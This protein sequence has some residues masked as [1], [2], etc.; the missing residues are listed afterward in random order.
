[1]AAARAR[2]RLLDLDG[3][4]DLDENFREVRLIVAGPGVASAPTATRSR[5]RAKLNSMLQKVGETGQITSHWES[6]KC[7][8]TGRSRLCV[9]K[10]PVTGL[11][12]N[13]E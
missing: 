1:M 2:L 9:E 11:H 4:A 5:P 10:W 6:F 3:I 13:A 8:E 7:G 12:G